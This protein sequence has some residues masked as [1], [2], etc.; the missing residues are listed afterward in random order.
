[1]SEII[2]KTLE[3]REISLPQEAIRS[4]IIPS[5]NQQ[6]EN[7]FFLESLGEYRRLTMTGEGFAHG[8]KHMYTSTIDLVNASM[9]IDDWLLSHEMGI[10]RENILVGK[11]ALYG[12][13]MLIIALFLPGSVLVGVMLAGLGSAAIN[14]GSGFYDYRLAQTPAE[15]ASAVAEGQEAFAEGMIGGVLLAIGQG[16]PVLANARQI[17]IPGYVAQG[18]QNIARGIC[19]ADDPYF[20]QLAAKQGVTLLSP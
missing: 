5:Q 16:V 15:K 8:A 13:M 2:F 14:Y 12:G 11:I 4:I 6:E 18:F 19:L 9:P 17:P 7:Q 10:S 3:G 20:L 1:M